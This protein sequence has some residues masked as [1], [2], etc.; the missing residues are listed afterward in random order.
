[1]R[2]AQAAHRGIVVRQVATDAMAFFGRLLARL[3]EGRNPRY[4][5]R[6]K[7]KYALSAHFDFTS[8]KYFIGMP[9]QLPTGN[10][11]K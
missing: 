4:L 7:S 10:A 3:S 9:A 5:Q 2:Q 8:L 6:V 1:M 11:A